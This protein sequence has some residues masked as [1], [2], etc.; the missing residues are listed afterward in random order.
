MLGETYF[1]PSA[2]SDD[3]ELIVVLLERA[4]SLAL[5]VEGFPDLAL[6]VSRESDAL[7]FCF[8]ATLTDS[9]AESDLSYL[10]LF[11]GCAEDGTGR[12][13][14]GSRLD[15]LRVSLPF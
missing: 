12:K 8:R 3:T 7:F 6:T 11:S 2:S 15:S 5:E 14:R 10:L 1:S 4:L 9:R 13:R